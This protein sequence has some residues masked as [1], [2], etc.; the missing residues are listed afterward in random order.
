MKRTRSL[1]VLLCLA[2]SFALV[3]GLSAAALA[4]EE[5]ETDVAV[6]E[7]DPLLIGQWYCYDRADEGNYSSD[8][9]T[10]LRTLDIV[11]PTGVMTESDTFEYAAALDLE[12]LTVTAADGQTDLGERLIDYLRK[13]RDIENSGVDE[14]ILEEAD[15][16]SNIEVTYE[17]YDL[18]ADD[19]GSVRLTDAMT[20][21]LNTGDNDGLRIHVT[22]SYKATPLSSQKVDVTY[23]YYRDMP[24]YNYLQPLFFGDWTDQSGNTW[25][26]D[27]V[28]DED[29]YTDIA[30]QMTGSDGTVYTGDDFSG[31]SAMKDDGTVETTIQFSFEEFDSPYYILGEVTA[32]SIQLLSEEGDLLLTRA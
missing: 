13:L 4:A 8:I 25:S 3:L 6:Q 31:Y 12:Q 21:M 30:F 5:T 9:F 15:K 26:F 2:L 14:T 11:L 7:I 1:R 20:A 24:D 18:K 23:F 27:F 22:A 19:L 28:L 32:E 29:G 16:L 10:M 17:V